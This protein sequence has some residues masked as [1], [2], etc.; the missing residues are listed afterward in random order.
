MNIILAGPCGAGK[1]TTAQSYASRTSM[2]F[3]DFDEHR[4]VEMSKGSLGY[5]SPC[6]VS[7][8]NLKECLSSKLDTIPTNFILDI[9]GDT[10][11]R[12][13]VDNRD[14]RAQIEWVK[15]NY[16]ARVVLLI[17]TRDVLYRRF[18]NSKNRNLRDTAD[19][20]ERFN[21]LWNDWL[22][23]GLPNWNDCAD[24]I[25]D[26]SSLSIKDAISQIEEGLNRISEKRPN[27]GST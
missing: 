22:T 2:A 8:L 21:V 11:F 25:I 16:S 27:T 14:R 1:S 26:V 6:S 3:L 12:P 17:I 4:S 18:S 13:G 15:T 20:L 19:L 23:I 9:G 24:L 5:Y 7:H 10:V